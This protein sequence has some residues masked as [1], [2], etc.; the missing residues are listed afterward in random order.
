MIYL[1]SIPLSVALSLVWYLPVIKAQGENRVLQ[2]K[3]YLQ[4]GRAHV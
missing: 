3:D 4:I 2:T 1:I